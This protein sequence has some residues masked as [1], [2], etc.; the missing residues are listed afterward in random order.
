MNAIERGRSGPRGPGLFS[1]FTNLTV[2]QTAR[3]GTDLGLVVRA[4]EDCVAAADPAVTR[5][6][7][8]LEHAL[9]VKPD[10]PG[11]IHLYIHLTEWSD[12]PHRALAY[13]ERL[14][15][16]APGAS[17]LVHMPSHTFYRVGRYKDAMMSNVNAVALDKSYD[18][19]VGPP[20]GIRGMRLH[21]HNIHFGMGG[22]L[23]AGGAE[24]GLEGDAGFLFGREVDAVMLATMI[25]IV[26]ATGVGW[27]AGEAPKVAPGLQVQAFAAPRSSGVWADVREKLAEQ[28]VSVGEEV[29]VK[30]ID[31]DLERRRISLSLKQAN[32]S[33]DPNGTEFDP[34]LYGMTTEYDE[35]GEYKYP[36]GFDP[37]SGA[38]LEGFDAQR[39]KW[40]QE[41]AAAQ[42]RWEQHKAAVAKAL[43]AEAAAPV[44]TGASSFSSE[45]VGGGTLADDESLE[46]RWFPIDRLPPMAPSFVERIMTAV[47]HDGPTRLT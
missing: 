39:E 17:H 14:A 46:V 32:E 45:T 6:M 19:L 44:E 3:R 37:E 47:E 41:Y 27:R 20:G 8:I 35:N 12:D 30:I 4:V 31:I 15:L 42:A 24:R 23:M 43:E 38:W 29:F 36:E 28:V 40:E 16:L 34:A 1:R 9:T 5:A 26:V 25:P 13:G 33:V 11:A 21:A 10:D 22:A 7:T 2:E 18:Q